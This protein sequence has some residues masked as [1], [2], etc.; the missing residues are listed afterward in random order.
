MRRAVPMHP[1]QLPILLGTCLLKPFRL[2]SKE[3]KPEGLTLE[4]VNDAGYEGDPTVFIRWVDN[5]MTL[6]VKHDG[7]T[8]KVDEWQT[9]TA[10]LPEMRTQKTPRKTA[11][12]SRR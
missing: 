4:I 10:T 8:R 11:R 3:G 9:K 12:S 5:T 7:V 2:E 1:G 6:F